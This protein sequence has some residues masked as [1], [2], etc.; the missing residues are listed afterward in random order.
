M[1]LYCQVVSPAGARYAYSLGNVLT[2]GTDDA[3]IDAKVEAIKTGL[4]IPADWQAAG[5]DLSICPGALDAPPHFVAIGRVTSV[6]PPG[7][8]E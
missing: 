6:P 1:I 7:Y 8:E 5:W 4:S 3:E 2:D